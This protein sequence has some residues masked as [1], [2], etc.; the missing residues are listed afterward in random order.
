LLLAHKWAER[1]RRMLVIV[2]ANLRKQWA[3]DLAHML[4]LPA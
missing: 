1:K 3:Q 2:L 4:Y